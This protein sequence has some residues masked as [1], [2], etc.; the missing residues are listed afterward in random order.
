MTD[1]ER[2]QLMQVILEKNHRIEELEAENQQLHTD[3]EAAN[4]SL[5]G[6]KSAWDKRCYD[7]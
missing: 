7:A 6:A 2:E 5:K 4:A 1:L 3:L